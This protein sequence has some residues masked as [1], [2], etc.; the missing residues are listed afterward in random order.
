[1]MDILELLSAECCALTI[2][3]ALVWVLFGSAMAGWAAGTHCL[4]DDHVDD[5]GAKQAALVVFL[6]WPVFLVVAALGAFDF[7][8]REGR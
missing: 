1:M 2:L 8:R 6:F 5:T 7:L 4:P 3:A